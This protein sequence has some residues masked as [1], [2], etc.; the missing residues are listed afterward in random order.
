[1]IYRPE[2]LCNTKMLHL[3]WNVVTH[4]TFI[5]TAP[6][7]Q[8]RWILLLLWQ[9]TRLSLVTHLFLLFENNSIYVAVISRYEVKCFVGGS[10]PPLS[11]LPS[12]SNRIL[13]LK[14]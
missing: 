14:Q 6:A 4:F 12:L 13:V 2:R 1:M 8:N 7:H 10:V 11:C 5:T 3:K 9:H